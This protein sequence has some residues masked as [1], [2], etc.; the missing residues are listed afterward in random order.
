MRMFKGIVG[1]VCLGIAVLMIVS[2]AVRADFYAHDCSGLMGGD[3]YVYYL[4]NTYYGHAD[5]D[6]GA[7]RWGFGGDG[8]YFQLPART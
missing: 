5:V 2:A 4:N 3:G 1:F 8:T 7:P 6:C